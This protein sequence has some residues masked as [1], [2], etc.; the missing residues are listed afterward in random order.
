MVDGTPD[1][2]GSADQVVCMRPQYQSASRLLIPKR[3]FRNA[4]WAQLRRNVPQAVLPTAAKQHFLA[5]IY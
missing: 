4:H 3:C 1:G 2:V 5:E